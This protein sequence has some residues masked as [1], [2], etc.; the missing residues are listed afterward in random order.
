MYNKD[1]MKHTEMPERLDGP[2]ALFTPQHGAALLPPLLLV[3]G[4]LSR[5]GSV[6]PFYTSDA[7][8]VWIVL[9]YTTFSGL[10]FIIFRQNRSLVGVVLFFFHVLAMLFILFVSGFLG[11][12]IA[13][14]V[15][16]MLTAYRYFGMPGFYFSAVEFVLVA[17]FSALLYPELP[18]PEVGATAAVII[19]AGYGAVQFT[20]RSEREQRSLAKARQREDSQREQLTALVNSMA[21]AVVATDRSGTI[22]LYNAGLLS[23]LDKNTGVSGQNID[24][25]L[26]LQDENG[27]HVQ[28]MDKAKEARHTFKREDLVHPVSEHESMNLFVNVA[29]IRA[30]YHSHVNDGFIITLRDITKEKSLEDERD[31]FISVVSHELR[32]PV[33]IAEGSISN[34]LFMQE[35][36]AKPELLKSAAKT[37][38]DQVLFLARM[39]N[40]LSTLSRAE[41]GVGDNQED[42]DLN[43]LFKDL[44][45]KY[46]KDANEKGLQ[47]N[48]DVGSKLPHVMQSRLYLEEILQNFITNA[49]KYT[50]EGSVTICAHN[51]P[52]GVECAVSDTGIGV[53]RSDQK[54]IFQKFYRSEDYRTRETNGTGLGLYVVKKLASKIGVEI[55]CKSRLNHG[56]RFG[57]VLPTDKT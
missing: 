2:R 18:A 23:L 3:F 36:A 22:K 42:I 14:W 57:F 15:L 32:T 12:T 8:F 13:L 30:G 34:L 54:K 21:D 19:L 5:A 1:K 52:R 17:I 53:S 25:L 28:I 46:G 6:N 47:L 35:K 50:Q 29:P 11:A 26:Q 16:L 27:K 9:T 24:R 40:D 41:R 10:Y 39:V 38:H 31:E 51:T 55:E 48:L 49:I 43:Q 37:A 4:L 44:Y 45:Q 20:L 33:A 7:L 56:S